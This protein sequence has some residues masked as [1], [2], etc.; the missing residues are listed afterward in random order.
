MEIDIKGG[1][2]RR[3]GS[4]FDSGDGQ[5]RWVLAFDGGNG[6]QLW[7]RWTIEMAFNGGGGGGVRWRQQCSTAF[8]GVGDGLRREDERVVQGQATQTRGRCFKRTTRDDGAT[9]SW[10][11]K[12]TRGGTTR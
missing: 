2:W 6:W 5:R 10:H 3:R 11:D 8:D 7:Q 4:A 12:T 9:T 1:G